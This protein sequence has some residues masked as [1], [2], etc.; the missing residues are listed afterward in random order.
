MSEGI[1]FIASCDGSAAPTNPGYGGYGVY[2]YTLKPSKRTVRGKHPLSARHNFTTKGIKLEKETEPHETI[3]IVEYIGVLPGN[4]NS[5]NLAEIEALKTA[6]LLSLEL[7]D[8][9]DVFI[10][11]DSSY[12]VDGYN[13]NMP[14]WIQ[15]GW[16]KSDGNPP[17]HSEKWKELNDIKQRLAD[18]EIKVKVT[19]V[20]GHAKDYGNEIADLFAV[21]GSNASRMADTRG[22]LTGELLKSVRTVKEY[23]DF[24]NYNGI[25]KS[26]KEMMFSSE[27]NSTSRVHYL[28]NSSDMDQVG[29]K[30][31]DTIYTVWKDNESNILNEIKGEFHV[32]GKHV[33]GLNR[34]TT[35]RCKCDL[36][37]LTEDK[38]LYGLSR[39]IGIKY[40]LVPV[41]E[42]EYLELRLVKDKK[43]FVTEVTMSE[44]FS[45]DAVTIFNNSLDILNGSSFDELTSVDVTDIFYENEKLK[46]TNKDKMIDLTDRLTEKY[47]FVIKPILLLGKDIPNYLTLN[48]LKEKAIR[49]DAVTGK[50]HGSNQVTLYVK[51][52]LNDGEV[53]FTNTE[54]KFL[55]INLPGTSEA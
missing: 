33:E 19:W 26:F 50:K 3:S 7:E 27:D 12:V 45:L 39:T 38:L 21:I 8:V 35:V 16:K 18:K 43:M 41:M 49:V 40:L 32:P 23:E 4:D 31:V 15:S 44:P 48:R 51:M 9:K 28:L 29:K 13:K 54:D 36:S 30:N 10:M 14:K 34:T 37:R 11:S 42:R 47:H 20:K 55:V 2:G 24:F 6:L 5:N 53:I 1:K 46:I 52:V 25:E 22:G 17:S